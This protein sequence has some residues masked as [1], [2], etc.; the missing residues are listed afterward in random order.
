MYKRTIKKYQ[1]LEQTSYTNDLHDALLS[2]DNDSFWRCF[3]SKFC[4]NPRN[5]VQ[6]EGEINEQKIAENFANHFNKANTLPAN[7]NLSEIYHAQRPSYCGIPFDKYLLFDVELI[8]TSIRGLKRG[9]AADLDE[10]TAEHLIHSHPA[11]CSVLYRLFNSMI[12]HN[13][14]PSGFGSS[15]TIPI[16]KNSS[17]QFSKAVTMDDF[18][19][20]S[21]SS[22]LSKI[23]EKCILDRYH[24][25]FET[26]D[27]Q[28]GFKKGL[29]CSHALFSMRNVIDNFVSNGST[30]NLCTLDIRK[31]F[32]RMSHPGLF[33][34]LM[35]KMIPNDLLAT[36]EFWFSMCT[37]CVRWENSYSKFFKITRGVRQGGVLSPHLFS[38]F[39]DDIFDVIH[40]AQ[41]GCHLGCLNFNIFLYAD[42]I[43][44]ITPSVTALQHL[45]LT[46]E[47]FLLS[48]D[49]ALNVKK[50]SCLRIGPR[51]KNTCFSVNSLDGEPINWVENVRYLGVQII[52]GKKFSISMTN[53]VTAYY[54]SVNALFSR[55][56]GSASEEC[57]IKLIYS[58]CVPVLLYGLEVC[59]LKQSQIKHLDFL[60]KRTIMKIFKTN[61]LEVVDECMLRFD[62]QL[63]SRLVSQRRDK[64]LLKLSNCEN[65]ACH[66]L[67]GDR[68]MSNCSF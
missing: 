36:L 19:G 29:G 1:Q 34:K 15:Y 46:V 50:S 59:S 8:D 37:T 26:S 3:K 53:N 22:I 31:A 63:F 58:K 41:T 14:V 51:F 65:D 32:D 2:K 28:F 13:V 25:F 9:K 17:P 62:I 68:Q 12:K 10:L 7:S 20:I 24:R 35:K 16:P 48:C 66:F 18:R 33:I 39:M 43:L 5:A 57:Y 42:D 44:L 30:V 40:S 23:F 60:T 61:S 67:I 21:I 4:H 49:M 54:R 11:L 45:I 64:F 55:L 52:S 47:R 27:F 56:K 6:I 38:V